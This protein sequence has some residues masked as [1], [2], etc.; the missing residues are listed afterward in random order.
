M[1]IYVSIHATAAI[2]LYICKYAIVR[3]T[4]SY[5]PDFPGV[6]MCTGLESLYISVHNYLMW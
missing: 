1:C 3:N 5:C 4:N 2:G 6:Y